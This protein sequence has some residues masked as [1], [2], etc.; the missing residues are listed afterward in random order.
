MAGGGKEHKKGA[1]RDAAG[2]VIMRR[3]AVHEAS[4]MPGTS[5]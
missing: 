5:M 3:V 1:Y 2:T 4:G